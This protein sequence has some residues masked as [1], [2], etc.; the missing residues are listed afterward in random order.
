MSQIERKWLQDG[1]INNAKIDQDATFSFSQITSNGPIGVGTTAPLDGVHIRATTGTAALRLD[2]ADGVNG[3]AFQVNSDANGHLNVKDIPS[4][5][6]RVTLDANGRIGVGTNPA[7]LLDLYGNSVQVGFRN[8]SGSVHYEIGAD[9]QDRL[10]VSQGGINQVSLVGGNVGIG[11]TDATADLH[12]RSTSTAAAVRLD[13]DGGSGRSW[14]MSSSSDGKWHLYDV[15]GA[16]DRLVV[17]STN[18][19]VTG[20]T[21]MNG[22]LAVNGTV[23]VVNTNSIVSDRMELN[24]IVDTSALGIHQA[25][26]TS[27]VVWIENNGSGPAAVITGSGSTSIGIGTTPTPTGLVHAYKSSTTGVSIVS[28]NASSGSGAYASHYAQNDAAKTIEINVLS[29]GNT[30]TYG[31]LANNNNV[32]ML[33]GNGSSLLLNQQASGPLYL[34]TNNAIKMTIDTSGNV[35]IGDTH[36]SFPLEAVVGAYIARIKTDTTVGSATWYVQ[37]S[38]GSMFWGKIGAGAY[39]PAIFHVGGSERMRIDAVAGNVGIGD[40][41]PAYPLEVV[42]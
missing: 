24:N 29:S 40:P 27:R 32:A 13:M 1:I 37:P 26:G 10:L 7:E 6:T 28:E 39:Y 18:M 9:A 33:M 17:S 19:T 22:G 21:T 3:R 16:A 5:L 30:G 20:D 41:N 35:G 15:D 36:P 11:V 8:A 38:T 14:D 4:G 34:A 23:T 42:V 25:S 12:I 31:G 2:M